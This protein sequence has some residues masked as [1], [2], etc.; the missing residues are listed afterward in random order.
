MKTETITTLTHS[1]FA[2]RLAARK[3]ACILSIVANTDARAKKT[4]NPFKEVRKE[5]Y[6][7]VVSGADYQASVERQG[8]EGFKAEGLPYGQF[9]SDDTKNKVIRTKDGKLQL[10][11]VARNPQK[12]IRVAWYADGQRV[13]K[14]VVSPYLPTKSASKKQEQVGVTGKK[15]VMVRNYDFA[16][17]KEVVMGGE[18]FTLIPD[19]EVSKVTKS[20]DNSKL[21]ESL[22]RMVISHLSMSQSRQ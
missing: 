21:N 3:G 2:A 18:K 19:E 15:Q 10:R 4:G 16:N 6:L 14:E 9:D 5:S 8:G 22:H 13:E 11:T 7:R 12:P 1:E 17:I 20:E